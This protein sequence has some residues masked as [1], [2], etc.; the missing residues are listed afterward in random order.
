MSIEVSLSALALLGLLAFVLALGCSALLNSHALR[1]KALEEDGQQRA[2]WV[3]RV[4]EDASKLLITLALAQNTVR[5]L[6]LGTTLAGFGGAFSLAWPAWGRWAGVLLASGLGLAV[7]ESLADRLGHRNAERWAMRLIPILGPLVSVLGPV[8]LAMRRLGNIGT[9]APA[10]GRAGLVTEEEIKTLVDAGEEG[11]A[12][13]EEE[14]EMILSIF[15]LS[16]TLARE[17]MVPRI[18][19]VAFEAEATLDDATQTLIDTGH[20]RA[21]VYSGTI[22]H[23][24]GLLYV[25]DILASQHAGGTGQHVR[26]IMRPA[27]FVPEAKKVDDLLEEMQARRVQMVIVV[28]EYGGTA[29]VVTLEDIVEEIV[30]E[31]RDEYDAAEEMRYQELPDGAYILSGGID[32]DDVNELTGSHLVK[33]ASETLSGLIHSQLG[34]VAAAGDVLETGGLRLKVEQVLGRRIRKVHAVRLEPRE[35]TEAEEHGDHANPTE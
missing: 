20:S 5:L 4:T 27:I 18:D 10:S 8:G 29:G 35:A 16:D 15:Q 33:D 19:I 31:I 30:G 17:V 26:D 11:G 32:L 34:R 21:P 23:V 14:K 6:F 3:T 28:D 22:D 25:K 12:I 1:L 24:V 2:V 13:E 7:L 9:P